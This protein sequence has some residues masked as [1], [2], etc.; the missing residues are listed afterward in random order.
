MALWDEDPGQRLW[1]QRMGL[2]NYE[3]ES[4]QESWKRPED[5]WELHLNVSRQLKAKLI[6]IFCEIFFSAN[7][8][9][10][11]ER[12]LGQSQRTI[13]KVRGFADIQAMAIVSQGKEAKVAGFSPD[14]FATFS[15]SYVLQLWA[16]LPSPAN[17]LKNSWYCL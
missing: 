5:N 12:H 4:W 10:S 7:P 6:L 1:R 11:R 2:G 14:Q 16:A 8:G 13:G 17:H 15:G 9:L 3:Q